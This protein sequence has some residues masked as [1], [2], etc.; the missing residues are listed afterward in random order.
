MVDR[1]RSAAEH[2]EAPICPDCLIEMK[3]F[4]S[5]LLADEPTPIIAHL[6]VCP[7]CKR[8]AQADSIFKSKQVP[9][10]KLSAPRFLAYAAY[11]SASAGFGARLTAGS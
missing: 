9:P 6:F 10:D 2:L 4:R 3:W 7:H 1:L 11:R 8:A 5:E